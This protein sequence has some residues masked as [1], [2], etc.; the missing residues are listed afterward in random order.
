VLDA[1]A[2]GVFYLELRTTPKVNADLAMSRRSYVDA[3]L[4]GVEA[5]CGAGGGDG[6]GSLTVR[7]LLSIDR[8][9]DAAAAMETVLLADQLRTSGVVGVDLSG[10]PS[11]GSFDTWLPALQEARRRGLPITLHCGEVPNDAEV[12][13]MLRFGPERLGHAVHAASHAGLLPQ[14]LASRVPV[15]LCLT[16]NVLSQSCAG[17]EEH[18]FGALFAAGHPVSVCTDDSGVF[19]TTLSREYALCA[20][21]FGLREEQLWQLAGGAVEAAFAEETVK[22]T[23]RAR[24][25]A[26]RMQREASLAAA[27]A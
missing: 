4:R 21:A 10:N 23:L 15:E 11:V 27:K 17:Y 25:A 2:D 16:S 3:V 14:L 5:A 18:H 6:S 22:A 24:L 20:V 9:G 7:L 26:A 12:A 1:A 8:R 19:R 13:E